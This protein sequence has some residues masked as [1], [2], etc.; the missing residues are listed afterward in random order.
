MGVENKEILGLKETWDAYW[1]CFWPQLFQAVLQMQVP[2]SLALG[3]WGS[4]HPDSLPQGTMETASSPVHPHVRKENDDYSYQFQGPSEWP[5]HLPAHPSTFCAMSGTL[6]AS[7]EVPPESVDM[8]AVFR[9]V[10][11]T[12]QR[13]T[14]GVTSLH[15]WK[16]EGGDPEQPMKLGWLKRKEKTSYEKTFAGHRWKSHIHIMKFLLIFIYVMCI[17]CC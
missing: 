11:H 8:L 9:V 15:P 1:P 17:A 12:E 4:W 6:L 10:Q 7:P 16:H 5:T 2:Q 14:H 3:T 13:H